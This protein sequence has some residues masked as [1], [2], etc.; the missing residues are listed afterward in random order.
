MSFHKSH[1][2]ARTVR[3]GAVFIV[4]LAC[5]GCGIVL[6]STV[7]SVS[8]AT[9]QASDEDF[10]DQPIRPISEIKG[11]NKDQ[12]ELGKKLFLDKR[13][14]K[15]NTVACASCHGLSTGG[16]D[17]K[18]HSTGINGAIGGINAPTVLNS[19]HNFIQFWDGRA[20]SLE[21]QVNG[22]THHPKEMGSNWKE[23]IGKLNSDP[24]MVDE[25]KKAFGTGITE[26]AVRTAIANFE[27][28]LTTLNAPFDRYLKG[29]KTALSPAAIRGYET[30]KKIGCSSCHQG[31]NVGGN[32]FAKLGEMDD[33]FAARKDITDADAGRF[34]VTKREKDK[35][36]FRVPTLR[37]VELT[38]PYFH[39]GSVDSLDMAVQ[40]MGY[41]QLGRVMDKNDVGD[42]VE[43]LKSLTGEQPET[44][45]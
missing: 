19:G 34:A 42:I 39:D 29:D 43:F 11:L 20:P 7:P 33:Y 32:M 12:V 25:F 17:Q 24:A 36:V 44:A 2:S 1:V 31:E 15:D 40:L 6:D 3:S 28:S 4:A 30:F 8:T 9:T 13:L 18:S 38:H 23:I 5:F 10:G 37:N 22:P 16:C 35:G 27:R 14:S 45:K 21:A 26:D 41:Y